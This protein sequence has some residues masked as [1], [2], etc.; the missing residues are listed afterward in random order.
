MEPVGLELDQPLFAITDVQPMINPCAT[1][2]EHSRVRLA[3]DGF[4]ISKDRCS[5]I[6][7]PQA[8]KFVGRMNGMTFG[9]TCQHMGY[10]V[11]MPGESGSNQGVSYFN[12]ARP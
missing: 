9:N 6:C 3:H 1:L 8:L 5:Q 10:S 7:L 12:F 4:H 11:E 2:D